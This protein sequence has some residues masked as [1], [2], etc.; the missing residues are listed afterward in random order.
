MTKPDLLAAAKTEFEQRT[1]GGIG[2]S[3]WIAPQH[4]RD[5]RPPI[6]A[7]WPE[8]VTT[9]RGEEWWIPAAADESEP[10]RT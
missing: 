6:D 4:P 9:T 10:T 5:L 1:G 3:T 2:G 7:R 8:Y